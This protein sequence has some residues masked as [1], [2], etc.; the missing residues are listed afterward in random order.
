MN[1]MAETFQA[2]R[3]LDSEGQR[4]W[5]LWAMSKNAELEI[6]RAKISS[7]ETEIS[8]THKPSKSFLVKLNFTN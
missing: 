7:L 2:F 3:Q 4:I 5:F 8:F 6:A 1:N